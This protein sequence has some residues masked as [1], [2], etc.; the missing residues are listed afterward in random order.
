MCFHVESHS[1]LIL[2]LGIIDGLNN[3]MICKLKIIVRVMIM[4]NDKDCKNLVHSP[5]HAQCMEHYGCIYENNHLVTLLVDSRSGSIV[6]ANKA[7]CAYYGYSLLEFRALHISDLIINQDEEPNEPNDFIKKAL[8]EG[9]HS[10]NQVVMD[11]HRL[12]NGRMV[13]VEIHTGLITMLGKKCIYSVIHDISERVKSELM[14]KESEERYRGLVELCP[15]PILVHSRGIILFVNNQAEVLFGEVKDE[16]IGKRVDSFFSEDYITS[17]VYHNF[18]TKFHTKAKET[19]RMEQRFIRYDRRIF[20]LEISGA[21]IIYKEV[22]ATQLVLRDITESKVEIERAVRLQEHRHAAPFPLENRV[23]LQKLY[24]PAATLSG[25]FFIFHKINEEQVVGIIGDVTGKGITAALNIS[26][27]RVLFMDSLLVTQDPVLLLQD[28]NHK[29]TQ[30]LEEDYVAVCCFNLDFREGRL[31]ASGAGINE[32]IYK[33]KDQN[34]K[35]MT[36]KGA[37]LGMFDNS[38]FDEV[39]IYFD[40]GDRFCFYS[41]GMDLLDDADE[42]SCDFEYLR[43]SIVNTP[44]QDDCTWL[45]LNI[46]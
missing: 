37:P 46:R 8:P 4:T 43:D 44:L 41:D 12:A 31:K 32:F 5:S 3:G 33:P 19:F 38:E 6:D 18:I 2:E 35:R 14:V 27:M 22:K 1:F 39:I 9:K 24:V 20:D 36:V 42:L 40:S 34:G 13:D 28:L 29:A 16:L 26:A 21:P 7:A 11:R 30:Y 17:D 10:G 23:D 45:S 15:E 25:D